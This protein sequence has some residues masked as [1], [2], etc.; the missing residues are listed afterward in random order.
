MNRRRRAYPRHLRSRR[1][2]LRLGRRRSTSPSRAVIVE[3]GAEESALAPRNER[4][5]TLFGNGRFRKDV[6]GA[7]ADAGRLSAARGRG[8]VGGEASRRWARGCGCVGES[9][10][11]GERVLLPRAQMR[12][13]SLRPRRGWRVRRERNGGGRRRSGGVRSHP[14]RGRRGNANGAPRRR[15]VRLLEVLRPQVEESLLPLDV[16]LNH[17]PKFLRKILDGPAHGGEGAHRGWREVQKLCRSG[18]RRDAVR[19]L[20]ARESAHHCAFTEAGE[21]HRHAR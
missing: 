12:P 5:E 19:A 6:G 13:V 9:G 20:A 2:G 15:N 8:G 14:R 21:E 10:G 17:C 4:L 7:R 1:L 16:P 3:T 18:G 11:D